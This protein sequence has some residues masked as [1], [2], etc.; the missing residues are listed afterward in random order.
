MHYHH[1]PYGLPNIGGVENF[2][3]LW[4]T[5]QVHRLTGPTLE[6]PTAPAGV[7]VPVFNG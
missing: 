1:V 3:S 5:E 6:L 4:P 7:L 2:L